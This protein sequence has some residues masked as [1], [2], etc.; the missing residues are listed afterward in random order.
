MAKAQKITVGKLEFRKSDGSLVPWES[1]SAQEVTEIRSRWS[2][3]LTQ[4]MSAYYS[5]H[6]EE[7][8]KLLVPEGD[9]AA[10]KEASVPG[11]HPCTDKNTQNL[12]AG[13]DD[14][15]T[16]PAELQA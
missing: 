5:A 3:K 8:A 14:Y 15:I 16:S 13:H 11:G 2:A 12:Q 9:E 10:T 1:L 4:T 7:Y 6:P